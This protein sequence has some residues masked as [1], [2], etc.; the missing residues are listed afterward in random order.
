MQIW[1][2]IKN[3]DEAFRL[4]FVCLLKLAG[5]DI[6]NQAKNYEQEEKKNHAAVK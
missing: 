1:A 5:R 3:I 2:K 4:S 6:S